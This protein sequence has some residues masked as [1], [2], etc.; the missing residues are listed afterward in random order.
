MF[1]NLT[2]REYN[3]TWRLQYS[4]NSN[5]NNQKKKIKR[6]LIKLQHQKL[7]YYIDYK[8]PRKIP[9]FKGFISYNMP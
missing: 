5:S 4:I 8:L 2:S 7:K 6:L 3:K 9:N 1:T